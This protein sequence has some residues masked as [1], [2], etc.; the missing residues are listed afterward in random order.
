MR[1]SRF[2]QSV[3]FV[4][5]GAVA[6]SL[7]VVQA[8]PSGAGAWL[9][10]ATTNAAAPTGLAKIKHVVVLMQEN[11]SYDSYFGAL[12]SQGQPAFAGR[13]DHGQPRPADTGC[14]D[15]TVPR[16]RTSA[17]SPTST[18][19]GTARTKSGTAGRWTASPP[20]TSIPPTPTAAARWATSTTACCRSITGIANQFSIADH[21][22]A[23]VLSQTFP[24][25]FYLLDRYLVRAHPQRPPA[26]RAAGPRRPSSSSSTR[27]RSAGRSTS[28]QVQI[29]VLFIVRAEARQPRRE[30]GAV[31]QGRGERERCRRCR[32]SS[33]V[34]SAA[35]TSRAT[36]TR[37]PTC[38]SARSS[39]TT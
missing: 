14:D 34:R 4:A 35:S 23:S 37:P 7:G 12:H 20:P 6:V 10:G 17:R 15:P 13:T 24:N 28:R 38:R 32:S 8:T 1:R 27:P 22:F 19:R 30:D 3:S 33:R 18:T 26:R 39:R 11:R 31:L 29:E 36:S 2:L 21:Y 5:A 9:P 25:R 16:R